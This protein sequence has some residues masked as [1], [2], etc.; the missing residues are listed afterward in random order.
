MSKT[1]SI[2][3]LRN[4]SG[5]DFRKVLNLYDSWDK[6]ASRKDFEECE[7]QERIIKKIHDKHGIEES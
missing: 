6:S 3:Q 4:K 7:R 5:A 1:P 2:E